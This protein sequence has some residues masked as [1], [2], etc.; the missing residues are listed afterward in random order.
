MGTMT[1]LLV[2]DDAA[3]PVELTLYPVSDTPHPHW[4]SRIAGVP[5][6]GQV[7]YSLAE[8]VLK[9]GDFKTTAK[10][11]VPVMETAGT[12]GVAGYVAPPRVAYVNTFIFTAFKSRRST[13]ADAANGFKMALGLAQG[14]SSTTA[15]GVLNQASVGGTFTASVLPVPNL[16]VNGESAY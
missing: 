15:T 1:N 8:E 2:K 4:A 12:A 6:D 13:I 5:R 16:F 10:L 11:E 9:S 3:T 7:R 14:A